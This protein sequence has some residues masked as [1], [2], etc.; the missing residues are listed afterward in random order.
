MPPAKK[1]CGHAECY[2]LVPTGTHY[3]AIHERE[4]G[5]PR[6]TGSTRSTAPG[7]HARE[8]ILKRADY[9]CQIRYPGICTD[10]ATVIDHV[11]ALGLGGTDDD[12]NCQAA[13]PV[14]GAK[15]AERGMR[16][17]GGV[18]VQ[19]LRFNAARR[20]AQVICRAASCCD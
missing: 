15:P 12:A 10:H 19:P 13:W 6:K 5:W 7:H 4:R 16:R 14:T 9:R 11:I 2:E 8:R 3:Y 18:L 17:D 1:V 20:Q